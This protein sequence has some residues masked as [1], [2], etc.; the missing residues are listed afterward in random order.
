MVF[1]FTEHRLLGLGMPQF[2]RYPIGMTSNDLPIHLLIHNNVYRHVTLVDI[3]KTTSL[4]P[5]SLDK[6]LQVIWRSGTDNWWTK[7]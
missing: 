2:Y 3:T 7:A 4:L 5:Y 6:S 1:S